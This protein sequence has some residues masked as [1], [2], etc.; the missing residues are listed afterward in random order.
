VP[1]NID[2]LDLDAVTARLARNAGN[3][4]R[5]YA[6]I[7]AKKLG[8]PSK[9]IAQFVAFGSTAAALMVSTDKRQRERGR[10]IMARLEAVA[11]A[12]G[13]AFGRGHATATRVKAGEALGAL[14]GVLKQIGTVVASVVGL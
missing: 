12:W 2:A 11:G 7:V 1:L 6:M 3:L 8:I 10:R 5:D 13:S 4:V 9:D 14:L